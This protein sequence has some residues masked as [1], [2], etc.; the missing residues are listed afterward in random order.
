VIPETEAQLAK[1]ATEAG[2]DLGKQHVSDPTLPSSE[3]V[4]ARLPAATGK[5]RFAPHVANPVL[6]TLRPYGRHGRMEIRMFDHDD[7]FYSFPASAAAYAAGDVPAGYV[8]VG[9]ASENTY[10]KVIESLNIVRGE[11]FDYQTGKQFTAPVVKVYSNV[12]YE[13]LL[14]RESDL[15]QVK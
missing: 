2:P 7:R 3:A 1:R 8:V 13:I 11:S 10:S 15:E 12:D 9:G 4:L 5:W 6:Y 14:A